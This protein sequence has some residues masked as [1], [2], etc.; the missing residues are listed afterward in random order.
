ML[1]EIGFD[2]VAEQRRVMNGGS[3]PAL[4]SSALA[5][6][7]VLTALNEKVRH[8]NPWLGV[9]EQVEEHKS[10]WD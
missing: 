8:E 10:E 2:A 4:A 5:T 3:I 9:V 6:G 1:R 7:N